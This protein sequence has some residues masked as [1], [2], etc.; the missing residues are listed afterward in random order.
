MNS[1]T[2]EQERED[3]RVEQ[4]L[5]YEINAD[6]TEIWLYSGLRGKG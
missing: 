6:H 1:D 2:I 3:L 4:L 5:S